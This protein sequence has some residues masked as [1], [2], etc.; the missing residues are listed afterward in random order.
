MNNYILCVGELQIL[1]IRTGFAQKGERADMQ[2]R[3]SG[4]KRRRRSRINRENRAA[5]LAITAVVCFLFVVLAIE[6]FRLNRKIDANEARRMELLS[7]IEEEELR[8]TE[9]EGLRER[10][11]SE[12]YIKEAAKEKLG[13]VEDGEVIFKPAG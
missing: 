13:L 4:R 1:Q 7:E 9:I 11:Q 8:T 12:D 2:T 3:R 6:G 5:M 10:M